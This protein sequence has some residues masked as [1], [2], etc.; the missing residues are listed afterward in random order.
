MK[1]SA[2]GRF[3]EKKKK[4][5]LVAGPD[6][7]TGTSSDSA[8]QCGGTHPREGYMKKKKGSQQRPGSTD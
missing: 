8:M 7:V 4:K 5:K 3:F 2:K 1:E 6:Q